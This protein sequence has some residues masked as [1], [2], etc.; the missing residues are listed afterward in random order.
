MIQMIQ[1]RFFF[2]ITASG[3]PLEWP[4]WTTRILG[5]FDKAKKPTVRH[6][7]P[8]ALHLICNGPQP[9]LIR[10]HRSYFHEIIITSCF[11][12]CSCAVNITVSFLE[13][14]FKPVH[15]QNQ[16]HSKE[17]FPNSKY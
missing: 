16:N 11:C 1:I 17:E 2:G 14:Y 5:F 13:Y 3:T 9:G 4:E 15:F 10:Y 7:C 12:Y 8:Y 6:M